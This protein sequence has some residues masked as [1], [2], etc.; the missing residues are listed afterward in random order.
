MHS[1][2]FERVSTPIPQG[3]SVVRQSTPIVAFGQFDSARVA[4]IGINPSHQEFLDRKGELLQGQA[5]RFLSRDALK[6]DDQE[7]LSEAQ[8]REVVEQSRRYFELNPYRSWFNPMEK[9]ILNPRGFSYWNGTSTHL[10]LSQWATDPIWKMLSGDTR[11]KLVNSDANFLRT[12]LEQGEFDYVFLNGKSAISQLLDSGIVSLV[13][14]DEV[15]CSGLR[16]EIWSG[17]AFGASF[18]GWNRYLQ[19]PMSPITR[20]QLSEHLRRIQ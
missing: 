10:D 11:T 20:E 5:A 2:E 3:L 4:S 8:A 13:L 17:E 1:F 14:S 6:V 16:V 7:P 19:S 18:I 12:Q 15:D 9:W